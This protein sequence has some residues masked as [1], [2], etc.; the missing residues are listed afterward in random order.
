MGDIGVLKNHTDLEVIG[1][2]DITYPVLFDDTTVVN[3]K[4]IELTTSKKDK[5]Q[6]HLPE[7]TAYTIQVQLKSKGKIK[8][9]AI[10]FNSF[11]EQQ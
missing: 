3:N 6:V 2:K 1:E 7:G 4:V 11:G 8:G 9:Y 10:E 5:D